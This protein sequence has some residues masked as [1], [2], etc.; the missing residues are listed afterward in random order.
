VKVQS[1]KHL[2]IFIFV[3]TI[4][5]LLALPRFAHHTPDSKHYIELSKY[6]QGNLSKESLHPP[7]AYRIMTPYLASHGPSKDLNNNFA[8]IN[9]IFTIFAYF[10]FYIY[11]KELFMHEREIQLG[12][13][14]LVFSFPSFNYAS[15]VLTDPA[16]FF[17]FVLGTYL[18][19]KK[20]FFFFSLVT[21]IGVLAREAILSLVLAFIIYSVSRYLFR[22]S[23]K[24]NLQVLLFSIP[25]IV[26]Y[27]LI[28][29]FLSD[30][31][32]YFWYPS[33][34]RVLSNIIRPVSWTT[35]LFTLSTPLIIIG[36]GLYQKKSEV[37]SEISLR[38]PRDSIMLLASIATA[39]IVLILY[40]ILTAFMSG[41][42]VWP[43]YTILI[44]LAVLCI[45]Q[46]II[47]QK[48]FSPLLSFLF[49]RNE[50]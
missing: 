12:M 13:L 45:N 29:T 35:F 10:M 27:L 33:I 11:L 14:L 43:F 3:V 17:F 34:H 49:G 36:L 4:T 19:L 30:L 47:F 38:F 42:F 15:G 23:P 32:H 26:S 5:T 48:L 7:H 28:R 37:I 31:P 22:I 41:R 1:I 39:C 40:S 44:P 2:R 46:T 18:L 21:S 24:L 8:I 25:P 6:F 16:G 20:H 9:L 50:R